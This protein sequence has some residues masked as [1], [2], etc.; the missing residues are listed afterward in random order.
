[1]D[2][3]ILN[4]SIIAVVVAG[5]IAQGNEK[6]FIVFR[7]C[8]SQISGSSLYIGK[9]SENHRLLFGEENSNVIIVKQSP[10]LGLKLFPQYNFNKK[11]VF[12]KRKSEGFTAALC[13][14]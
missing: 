1:M 13:T 7:A 5:G 4:L 10:V 12:K 8:W 6:R 9:T 14:H 3:S 2:K 11:M